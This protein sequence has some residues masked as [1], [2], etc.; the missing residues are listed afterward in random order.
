MKRLSA[1]LIGMLALCCQ[2]QQSYP[3]DF[4]DYPLDTRVSFTGKAPTITD[5]LVS[6]LNQDETSEVLG[7]LEIAWNHYVQ[8]EP[9]EPCVQFMVD[10]K[11][12][13][14]RHT[15]DSQLCEDL[16]D[17][18]EDEE[19]EEYDVKSYIEMCY[20]NCAD[21]KHKLLAENCITIIDGKYA[22]TE[23]S[24]ISFF[25]YDNDSRKLF[26]VSEED[27]GAYIEPELDDAATDT[28]K[29]LTAFDDKAIVVYWLPQQG[30][31]INVEIVSGTKREEARLVW[32]GMRF[33]RQ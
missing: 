14:L 15:D 25:I 19:Y 29:A 18:D 17:E 10:E 21:G 2:A 22:L 6:F 11:N 32:D 27:I 9:Q 1:L 13:Y 16:E 33:K 26:L 28:G 4:F 7:S 8:G 30:K 23:Y 3:K 5:F 31:D 20:W 12:G 24:G